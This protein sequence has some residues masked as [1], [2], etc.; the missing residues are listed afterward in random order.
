MEL[1][2]RVN[3]D[4]DVDTRVH[5]FSKG[6]KNRL[7]VARALLNRPEILF[8]DEPT[9][10]LDPTNAQRITQLIREELQNGTTV[11]LTT[12]DMHAAEAVCDRVAFITEGKISAIDSPSRFKKQFGTRKL[13][14]EFRKE[15]SLVTELFDLDGLHNNAQFQQLL[16]SGTI[17]TMHTLEA[18]LAEVFIE[19]TGKRLQ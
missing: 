18:T 2:E 8:L 12:H 11:F 5:Q 1:L 13:Q 6:M 17:E 19:V 3:L 15:A 14:V 7:T 10:G 16:A 4:N 9:A